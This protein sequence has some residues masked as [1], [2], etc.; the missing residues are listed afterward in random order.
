M[1]EAWEFTAGM[2]SV[3][4]HYK[5]KNIAPRVKEIK[6]KKNGEGVDFKTT[7]YVGGGLA[8]SSLRIRSTN[9]ADKGTYSCTLTNAVGCTSKNMKFGNV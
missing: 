3:T 5:I 8:D 7:K 1:F 6:W 2:E 4:I 9:E